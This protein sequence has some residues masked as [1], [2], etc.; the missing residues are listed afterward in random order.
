MIEPGKPAPDFTLDTDE[1]TPASLASFRG[2][3]VVLYW[4]PKAD[5]SG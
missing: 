4:F 3:P 1:G 5:T 2:R